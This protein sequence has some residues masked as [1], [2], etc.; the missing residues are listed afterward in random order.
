MDDSIEKRKNDVVEPVGA[1]I[2]G[3]IGRQWSA[4]ASASISRTCYDHIAG[5][6]GVSLYDRFTAIGWLS[7]ST[8]SDAACELTPAGSAAFEQTG[9]DVEAAR[10]LRPHLGGALGA[11]VLSLTLQ[12]RW[13]AQDLDSRALRVTSTGRRELLTRFGVA[14]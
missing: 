6:L 8:R 9:V 3:P 10:K 11:A 14:V 7:A 4:G 12:R 2:T 1:R 5:T 13:L